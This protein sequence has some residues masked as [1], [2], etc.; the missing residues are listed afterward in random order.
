MDGA[1][2]SRDMLLRTN[3][4]TVCLNAVMNERP[5]VLLAFFISKL[6]ALPS[7]TLLRYRRYILLSVYVVWHLYRRADWSFCKLGTNYH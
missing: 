7:T 6:V 4:I 5:S 1:T 3:S 2:A